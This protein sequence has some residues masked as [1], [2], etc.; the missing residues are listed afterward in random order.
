MPDVVLSRIKVLDRTIGQ[1]LC[2]LFRK[3]TPFVNTVDSIST[4]TVTAEEQKP[5]AKQSDDR[6]DN[7]IFVE[8]T[9]RQI[10]AE[11][12]RGQIISTLKRQGFQVTDR[13]VA[14]P[15]DVQKERIRQ[16]HALA[17]RH[18]IHEARGLRQHE[19]RL[20]RY[21]AGGSEV[22]PEKISPTLVEVSRGSEEEL[23]FRYAR[24]HWSIPISAGQQGASLRFPSTGFSKG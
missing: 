4:S 5:D 1:N 24:L 10:Q 12:L 6:L 15:H 8:E 18:R 9:L 23:L 21:I 20:L 3:E 14:L 2:I 17:V 11:V 7:V 16:L 19:H 13:G 22:V